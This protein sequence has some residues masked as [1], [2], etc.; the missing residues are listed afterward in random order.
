MSSVADYQYLA[1]AIELA[2]R[3]LYTTDPN[4]RVGC[5]VVKQGRV[6]GE[7]WHERAGGPH[8]ERVALAAAGPAARGAMAFVTL[9]PCNHTA[10][11]GPCTD[12]LIEAGIARV[13]CAGLDPNPRVSGRGARVL[14]EAGIQVDVGVLADA[15]ATLNPGYLSRMT[16]GRPYVRSK[17]AVSLDGRTALAD[18]ESQWI[19]GRDARADAHRWRAR[20]SAILTGIGTVLADDPALDARLGDVA[21]TQPARVII[22][23]Q[24]RTPP[25]AKTLSRPGEVII[26]TTQPDVERAG[27]LAGAGARIQAVSGNPQCDLT[28][29]LDRL[30][31]LEIN[32]VWVEAGETLN[33]A[34]V[35]A[36]LM[37]ELVIYM[38]PDVLGRDARGMFALAP[39]QDLAQRPRF[40]Y[41]DVRRVGADL[42]IIARPSTVTDA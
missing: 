10:R 3:G 30:G 39:L 40:A 27:P 31:R 4:P 16:R 17:L 18:G 38:A 24:L 9:E 12:A 26:F 41:Q 32:E 20:S 11:T 36:G 37:D 15:A 29:V 14:E 35:A 42:R 2:R 19:T 7:G 1:R 23:T 25:G 21:V 6:L 34:L 13:V 28:E 5:V 8:A 22:D 33:G